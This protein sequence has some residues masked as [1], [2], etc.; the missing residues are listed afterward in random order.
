MSRR[1]L[2][3]TF[4]AIFL[5]P[6]PMPA[7]EKQSPKK[8][9]NILYI[10]SDDH[11]SAAIGAYNSWLKKV[12]RTPNLDRLARQGIRFNNSLVTNSICTPCRAAILTGQY[13]HKN[14]VYTLNDTIDPK[15]IHL[16]HLL[17]A[18]GYQTAIIGKWHL[19]TDPAG[20]DYWNILPGQGVYI[21]P[22][23]REIGMKKQ[24]EYEGYSED[25]IN[26]MSLA[27]MQKREPR[28]PFL[29]YCDSK[30]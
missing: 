24:R 2:L 7:Q 4:A 22:K 17:Q 26:D 10:M 13:S 11:A 14:G 8:R 28:Q 30:L 12:V 20:F 19:G 25:V 5:A 16:G 6:S 3:V 27:R 15:R 21:Q 9:P 23:L 29:H 18:L 1:T